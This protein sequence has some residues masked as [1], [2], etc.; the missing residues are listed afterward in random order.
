MRNPWL[1]FSNR[2]LERAERHY[3]MERIRWRHEPNQCVDRWVSH[4]RFVQMAIDSASF[5]E[6]SLCRNSKKTWA[7]SSVKRRPGQKT[8][9]Q[10]S[11]LSHCWGGD[12]QFKLET[13]NLNSMRVGIN[14]NTLTR[15][16]RDTVAI[17][18]RLHVSYLWIDSLCILQDPIDDWKAESSVM[19]Q[20]Y[21][22]AYCVISATASE[23]SRSG[24][25]RKRNPR[26]A[27]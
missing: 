10:I 19:G 17:S 4:P 1:N 22:N 20:V 12:V 25:F 11:A 15:N 8:R 23:S 5:N 6:T 2:K 7:T 27:Q 21:S 26:S 13:R 16:F 18:R 24:R 14:I 9:Y 3:R